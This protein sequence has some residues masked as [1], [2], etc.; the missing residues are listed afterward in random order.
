MS[1]EK[2]DDPVPPQNIQ[3]LLQQLALM[4]QPD[5]KQEGKAPE[6]Y[7]FWNTQPVPKLHQP[8][9]LQTTDGNELPEGP[10]L[11]LKLSQATAKLAPQSLIEGFVWD[12]VDLDNQD[13]LK[14]LYTLLFNH[15]VEDTEGSFRFNY[16]VEFLN[17]ALKAP[18]ARKEWHLGVRT[19]SSEGRKGKLTAFISGVPASI[20]IG[21]APIGIVEI[22]F[23][24]IHRKLRSKGLTP[25]LIKEITRRC[26]LAGTYQALYTAG[27]LLPTPIA[28]CRY[29]HRSLDWRH[30]YKNGFSAL[31]RNA[32]EQQMI[33]RY[34]LT[35]TTSIKG[36]RPMKPAD[37]PQVYDL[38]AR[39]LTRFRMRQEFGK[40]EFTHCMCSDASK[41]V[42]WSYVVEV[43]G[44]I[45]DFFSYYL[46][47]STVLKANEKVFIR[48]AYLYYYASE[49]AFTESS[50]GKEKATDESNNTALGARLND[51][52]RDALILAKKDGFHVFN[53][54]SLMD[55]PLFL[56][57]QKFEAG[58]GRLHFYLF[59]YRTAKLP[60]GVNEAFVADA[61]KMGGV[62]VVM[63]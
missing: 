63:L 33:R 37:I 47:E 13:E 50:K 35:S 44:K 53:A 4:Q 14:E 24:C 36:L 52:I 17:W 7:K 26:Y 45:T 16:S 27:T 57:N 49:S 42:V 22:N 58:D 39:Y 43:N 54:L 40:E 61:T 30:L 34:F 62:G 2:Q 29:Y 1:E 56:Q 6:D 19:K 41:G 51:L 48:A 12:D 3:G 15:Y 11:P 25:V 23:L 8:N 18:G 31:P 59:N 38:L 20:K 9:L 10:I 21:D 28:T 55:N 5:W 46:L 60:S 32:T